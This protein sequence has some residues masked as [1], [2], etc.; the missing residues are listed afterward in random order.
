MPAIGA[1][2]RDHVFA[3]IAGGPQP[4]DAAFRRVAADV[5]VHRVR[6]GA[7][8]EHVAGD[9]QPRTRQRREQVD[10]RAE[11]IGIGVV[12]VIDDAQSAAA[13]QGAKP[14]RRRRGRFKPIAHRIEAGAGL[15]CR[16]RGGDGVGDIVF[17]EQ[18]QANPGFPAGGGEGERRLAT[19]VQF[20]LPG[21]VGGPARHLAQAEFA[22]A[23]GGAALAPGAGVG[24]FG[25]QQQHA[26]RL[27]AVDDFALGPHHAGQAA[28]TFGVGHGGAGD[29]RDVGRGGGG[30][31]SDF[32]SPVGTHFDHREAVLR[33]QPQQR[34]WDTHRIVQIG[35]GN[36]AWPLQGENGAE[37]LLHR[38]L[39]LAA[40]DG[41]HGGAR[42]PAVGVRDPRQR[43]PGIGHPQ[44]GQVRI[45]EAADHGGAG[46]AAQ[47]LGHERVAVEILPRQGE[48]QLALAQAAGVGANR[49]ETDVAA[50]QFA[51]EFRAKGGQRHLADQVST[52]ADCR[53][54]RESAARAT[55]ASLKRR[56]SVPIC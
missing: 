14:P 56:I 50:A 47:R 37:H 48:E 19:A 51:A 2:A 30:A 22:D 4:L 55:S 8:F 20:D 29:Q 11:G 17:A 3:K 27:E 38:G 28:K 5:P 41:E 23:V 42:A 44:L 1:E 36:Q 43:Q 21:E 18:G 32:P 52:P 9:Q 33:P 40:G 13:R 46:A 24:V 49:A 26:I 53:A 12:A 31:E 16:R 25:V 35:A 39:A 10:R 6:A 34:Q 15:E 45:A 54:R 7:E